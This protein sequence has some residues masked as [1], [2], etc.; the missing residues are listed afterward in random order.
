MARIRDLDR[1]Q[2]WRQHHRHQRSSGLTVAAYCRQQRVSAAAF[3]AWKNRLAATSRP[4]IPE[5]PLFVPLDVT[6][7]PRQSD[8]VLGHAAEIELPRQVRLRLESL[9]EPEWICRVVAGLADLPS[10]ETMP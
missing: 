1:E 2:Y 8:V 4:A 9:P 7:T 10:R 6:S 5:P 3:Y